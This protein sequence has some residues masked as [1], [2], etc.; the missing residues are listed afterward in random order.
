MNCRKIVID[1]LTANGYDGLCGEGCGCSLNDLIP[2][3]SDCM[4]CVPAYKWEGT[5]EEVCGQCDAWDC[6]FRVG[7]GDGSCMR[8][9]KQ[10]KL[11]NPEES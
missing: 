10:S 2:C 1:Y 9:V 6:E 11:K 3:E 4:D 7:L 8:P 5:P